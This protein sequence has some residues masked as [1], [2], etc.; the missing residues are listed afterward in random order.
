[1]FRID[2]KRTC[3]HFMHEEGR[4]SMI[5][6]RRQFVSFSSQVLWKSCRY[7]LLCHGRHVRKRN[8]TLKVTFM[9][10]GWYNQ[11]GF[12]A[13]RLDTTN[14]AFREKRYYGYSFEVGSCVNAMGQQRSMRRPVSSWLR[15][16]TTCNQWLLSNYLRVSSR[17]VIFL[18]TPHTLNQETRS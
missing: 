4:G 8:S 18:S 3:H 5:S 7:F 15:L 16:A 9:L 13:D 6:G 12:T 10:L 11:R 2:G 14:G 17:L 1:M